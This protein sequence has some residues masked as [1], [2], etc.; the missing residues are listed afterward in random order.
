MSVVLSDA[1]FYSP[2]GNFIFMGLED[3]SLNLC[4]LE[5]AFM[6]S[7]AYDFAKFQLHDPENGAIVHIKVSP[8]G[9]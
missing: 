1:I 7:S 6:P 8:E 4:C 5:E 9:R 3:G 2:C